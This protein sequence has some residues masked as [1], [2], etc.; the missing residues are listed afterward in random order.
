MVIKIF[1][2][3]VAALQVERLLHRAVASISHLRLCFCFDSRRV[4][5]PCEVRKERE[6]ERGGRRERERERE[7]S[8]FD[9]SYAASLDW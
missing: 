5:L 3:C 2:S 9:Y 7:R 1:L 6:R 8:I 4:D